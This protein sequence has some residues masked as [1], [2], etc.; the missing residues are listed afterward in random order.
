MSFVGGRRGTAIVAIATTA[1][2]ATNPICLPVMCHGGVACVTG[3]ETV[4]GV[5]STAGGEA[6]TGDATGIA[7]VVA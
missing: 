1:I 2:P 7:G 6:R 5:D 3:A 4:V